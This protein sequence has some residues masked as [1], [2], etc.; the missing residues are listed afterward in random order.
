MM[1]SLMKEKGIKKTLQREAVY[2]ALKNSDRPLTAEEIFKNTKGISLATVYR[3][4]DT[5]AEKGV[6]EKLTFEDSEKKFYELS[7]NAHR[8]YAVCLSCR[9][10]E[11]VNVCPV[12]DL[13]IDNF[14]ITGHRL[15]IYGYCQE[16][17]KGEC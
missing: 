14:E 6:I 4:L 15:E 7:G 13:S 10:M 17:R 12:H 1:E 11:Y 8:H 2:T 16:C 5:F 9:H 3:T